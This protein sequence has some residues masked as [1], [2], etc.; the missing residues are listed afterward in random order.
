VK[1]N[2]K[3]M[4]HYTY[5]A[6]RGPQDITAGLIQADSP[7]AAVA[8]I[9]QSGQTPLEVKLQADKPAAA[10]RGKVHSSNKIPLSVLAVFTRQLY[11]LLDAELPLLRSLDILARQKQHASLSPVIKQMAQTVND[12]ASLSTAMIQ[13]SRI[14]GPLYV[15]MVKSGES[16]G[17]L[18]E[19]L[20]RLAMFTEKDLEIRSKVRSSL[21]YP[22]IILMVGALTLFVLLT[23]VLPRLTTMFE[24][25]GAEL[26][27]PTKIVVAL[28]GFF[29]NFWWLI[30]LATAGIVYLIR[31]Y[32]NSPRGKEDID[33]R[34]LTIPVIS[35]F[36]REAELA[37]FARTLGTL[38]ESR[39]AIPVAL[40]STA[41]V[42]G[43]TVFREEVKSIAEKVR[44]GVSLAQALK[45]SAVF[46][47]I[48]I[49]I[50]AVG[51]ETGKLEK[52]LEKLARACDRRI[53]E[54]SETFVTILG[55]LVLVIVV[56]IVGFMVVSMLLPM[57][58]MNMIIN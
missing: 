7:E 11:D 23:F 16:S 31:Q 20:S 51:E 42:M 45:S 33:R 35:D 52:G 1:I 41:G 57:F 36:I 43:N 15:N 53:Q 46:S 39:I 8:K 40:E 5:K 54:T 13:H 26:P 50:V 10:G 56:G 48:A 3:P 58:K 49:N 28:S 22:L 24:D 29:S 19:V 25:F 2:N 32:A 18:P 47:D 12:G 34:V 9:I 27:L 30:I 37:S 38:L 4:P 21:L 55:P 17:H 6:K 14:F 44:A